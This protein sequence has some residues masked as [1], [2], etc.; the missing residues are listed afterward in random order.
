MQMLIFS[1]THMLSNSILSNKNGLITI[2]VV[3]SAQRVQEQS[4]HYDHVHDV[5]QDIFHFW[6]IKK[7][8]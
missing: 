7:L 5:G 4:V 3:L 8:I 2:I 1:K 6:K